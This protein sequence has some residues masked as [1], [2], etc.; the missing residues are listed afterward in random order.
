MA[1]SGVY[2]VQARAI[3]D[4]LL[5]DE[6]GAGGVP[7]AVGGLMFVVSAALLVKALAGRKARA[8]SACGDDASGGEDSSRPH[9]MAL[10][11]LAILAGYVL[12]LPV[13]GYIVS[14]ALLALAV[15]RFAGARL[16]VTLVLFAA[17]LG[18]LLWFV[19]DRLLK[20]R[21]PAGLWPALLGG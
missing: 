15:G 5:A 2:I 11:L 20:I 21:M 18:P 1:L 8:E 4:S 13:A 19:F 6:V 16:G 9:R 10:G 7:S 3:E 12:L 17:C 14:L